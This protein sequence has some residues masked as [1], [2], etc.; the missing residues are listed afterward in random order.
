M[1]EI[2]PRKL[3]E[4]AK[5]AYD[6]G[7]FLA[8]ARS[9]SSAAE[10]LRLT[11]DELEAAEAA[12]NASVAYLQAGE[13]EEALTVVEGTAAIFAAAGDLRR[14]GMALGNLAAALEEVGRLEEA[15][16]A[17]QQSAELLEQAG[18]DKL[19]ASAMQS[20]SA[21]QFR[22]GKQ[23][24]ALASMQSGLEGVKK[25]SVQQKF[26]KR[27]LSIPFNLLKKK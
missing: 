7:D 12:N 19:R 13:A 24:Q 22:M 20:L 14:Q 9:F 1:E 4:E 11:K 21:L 2:T 23:L 16:E 17:Y 25:P 27:L 3:S 10:G 8:A 6:R 15:V 18:E 26:L 5:A